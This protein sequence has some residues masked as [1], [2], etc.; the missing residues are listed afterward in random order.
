MDPMTMMAL[1]QAAS[2]VAGGLTS[3]AGYQKQSNF[4]KTQKALHGLRGQQAQQL[5][6]PGGGYENAMGILQGYLDPNSDQ[7]QNFEAPY[8]QE[9][10]QQTVPGLAERFAGFGANSGALS[11]S[12]FGQ[13]LG[14]AGSNL[15]T[16]LAQM[17]SQMQRNSISD[18]LN[19]YNQMS[20]G[21]MSAEPFSYGEQGPGA[22]SNIFSSFG[23]M[24]N[25]FSG[26]SPNLGGGMQAP[27]KSGSISF[28]SQTPQP[29]LTGPQVL[30]SGSISNF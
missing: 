11:S 14:A 13:A 25:P 28:G 30:K 5:G 24:Q 21:V 3:K 4:D 22:L 6:G 9:F 2:S 10:N 26:G 1:A 16:N 27:Q 29:F 20:S 12:G 8:M 23:G 17:K 19:Q 7:Y 18:I 15:Q